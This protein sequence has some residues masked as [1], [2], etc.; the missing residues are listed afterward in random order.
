MHSDSNRAR[1]S[2]G[3]YLGTTRYGEVLPRRTNRISVEKT[4]LDR[5]GVP[6]ARIE[7]EIGENEKKMTHAMYD[8]CEEILH[9]ANAEIP[10]MFYVNRNLKLIE[11][12][13]F[14]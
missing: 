8:T 7:Y 12:R 9:A 3:A 2:A 13:I 5:Y 1:S 4:P 10:D 14:D 11:Q 6:I